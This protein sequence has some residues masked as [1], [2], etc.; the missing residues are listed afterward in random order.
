M[1]YATANAAQSPI[2]ATDWGTGKVSD[3]SEKTQHLKYY[4]IHMRYIFL[5]VKFEVGLFISFTRKAMPKK[6]NN[7]QGGLSFF[8]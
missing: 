2:I 1:L 7:F 3:L 6:G 4:S 8:L 5:H